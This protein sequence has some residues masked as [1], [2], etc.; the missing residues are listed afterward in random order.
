M[1]DISIKLLDTLFDLC[2]GE[3]YVILE[4]SEVTSRISD[5]DFGV[6]ELTEIFE[7]LSVEG[8]IDLKYS[9]NQEFCVAMKTKGRTFIKQARERMQHLE[10]E[11]EDSLL[12][13][14]EQEA[15]EP[16]FAESSVLINREKASRPVEPI[17]D[18][19]PVR[20][21]VSRK[22]EAPV[23]PR[24]SRRTAADRMKENADRDYV[25]PNL[26]RGYAVQASLE[27][28]EEKN[29][30]KEKKMIVAAA[31]GAAAGSLLINL[32]FLV[33]FFVKFTGKG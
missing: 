28:S 6:D 16:T 31:L 8:F 2:D 4:K 30:R 19:A 17:A 26:A 18:P 7:A 29:S 15:I 22:E 20:E 1:D 13:E 27:E 12:A 25:A 24:S 3:N 10:E 9:D 32:I 11:G 14:Q 21:R 33:I 5:Y 23:R